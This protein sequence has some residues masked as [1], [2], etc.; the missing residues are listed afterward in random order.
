VKN[1]L[2]TVA[3]LWLGAVTWVFPQSAGPG[4]PS[5]S[6]TLPSAHQDL[7]ATYCTSCHNER[8]KTAGLA[9]DRISVGDV[10]S[11]ADV[12]ENVVRKVR[13]GLMPPAGARRP[14]APA[15]DALVTWLETE[16]DRVWAARPNPGRPLL[17]RLNRAWRQ[18]RRQG[19]AGSNADRSGIR[20]RRARRGAAAP[21]RES[22]VALLRAALGRSAPN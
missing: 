10:S 11:A 14:D 13:G 16:L 8:L 22:V 19:Q 21:V 3:A 1:R 6:A 7:I 2:L 17:R 4:A 15:R 5:P 18:G 12:W 9:L 20:S